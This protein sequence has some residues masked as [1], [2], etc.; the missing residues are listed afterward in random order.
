MA[1]AL[2]VLVH[3]RHTPAHGR[4]SPIL[5]P[6]LGIRASLAAG[7]RQTLRLDQPE[8]LSSSRKNRSISA[9]DVGPM[10]RPNAAACAPVRNPTGIRAPPATASTDQQR[11]PQRRRSPPAAQQRA[12]LIQQ[13]P[14]LDQLIGVALRHLHSNPSSRAP[15]RETLAQP[16]PIAAGD[17][18]FT[19]TPGSA[20]PVRNPPATRRHP[21]RQN[22]RRLPRPDPQTHPE[23]VTEAHELVDRGVPKTKSPAT[24]AAHAG[25]CTTPSPPTAPTHHHQRLASLR[26]TVH[27]SPDPSTRTSG[28]WF[29]KVS[30]RSR[31]P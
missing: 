28:R 10:Y 16:V 30:C 14:E 21:D 9:I 13:S 29:V 26:R 19:S 18:T 1:L 24:S 31:T 3:I 20:A 12:V 8:A 5:P 15:G 2:G 22:Q 23:Q 4:V 11:E 6:H 27:T 25:R 7:V 17:S